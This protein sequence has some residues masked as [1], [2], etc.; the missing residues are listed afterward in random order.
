MIPVKSYNNPENRVYS[1]PRKLNR[2]LVVD[3]S[4][5]ARTIIT[6]ILKEEMPDTEATT[7]G[8][9]Q[10]ACAW[11]ERSH[12]DL[13]TTSL[14]LPDRD[15][16]ELCRYVR[17]STHHHYTPT[18]VVSGD[19]D[20][21]LLKEGFN[22]GVTDYFDKL[23]GYHAFASFIMDFIQRHSGLVGRIL[24][25]E[26]SQLAATIMLRLMKRHGL[27]VVH[28]THAEEAIQLLRDTSPGG[29]REDES[30][31]IVIT[32]F[33]LQGRLT[34][35]D[36]LHAI[37][38]RFHYS[39][40]EM[41]VLVLTGSESDEKQV[42]VFHAGANDFVSKPIVEEVLMARI[43]S[44]LMIRQQFAALKRQTDEMHRLSITDS[45]TR[46]YNRRYLLDHGEQFI[47]NR[48]NH[49]VAAVLLD[50]DHFKQINDQLGHI[51]GDRVLEAL[52]QLLLDRIPDNALP[53][54]FGGE[55]FALLVPRCNTRDA[56]ICAEQLRLDIEALRPGNVPI[57]VSI[58]LA[59]NQ[60]NPD[61]AL[62]QLIGNADRALY[63]AKAQG[64][65]QVCA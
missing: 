22:A 32:D 46:V 65:N 38:A 60:L 57:T 56:H 36:L 2:I 40:Q 8:T 16:L 9:V 54:R 15:G 17:A 55:E 42:E 48:T 63:A 51:T 23:L 37:R 47:S 24:Y 31:D 6:R 41:P 4:E 26:D 43:R 34:G 18:I 44:L 20:A 62:T 58:G 30:F 19:A 10:E 52:G 39:Q 64:R 13:I 33:Y 35:G 11:L 3:G 28:T 12:F 21:R 14:M 45:L 1:M 61:L 5:V 50:I 7:C 29:L 53:V 59:T 25:V 49:P 27:Q